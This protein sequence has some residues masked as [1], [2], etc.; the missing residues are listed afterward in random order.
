MLKNNQGIDSAAHARAQFWREIQIQHYFR[1]C[2]RPEWWVR[3][4]VEA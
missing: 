1:E 3:D 4:L 2:H